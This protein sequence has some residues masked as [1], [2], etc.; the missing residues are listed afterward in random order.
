MLYKDINFSLLDEDFH[1]FDREELLQI[2]S[3]AERLSSS[4]I[5]YHKI[6]SEEDFIKKAHRHILQVTYALFKF[7]TKEQGTANIN[8]NYESTTSYCSLNTNHVQIGCKIL[9]NTDV[10]FQLRVDTIIALVFHELYHKRFTVKSISDIINIQKKKYYSDIHSELT[11]ELLEKELPTELHKHLFNI[12]EDKRIEFLGCRELPG[13]GFYFD[14]LRKFAYYLHFKNTLPG[15]TISTPLVSLNHVFYKVLIPEF[16]TPISKKLDIELP[17]LI[18]G[19]ELKETTETIE[20]IDKYFYDN[21]DKVYSTSLKTI[22]Q[23]VNDLEKL[24]PERLKNQINQ[25]L[26]KEGKGFM[27]LTYHPDAIPGKFQVL[28][29]QQQKQ[30]DS[31]S[32]EVIKNL[33]K[34]EMP[35]NAGDETNHMQQEK[36]NFGQEN[37]NEAYTKY[38]IHD[39]NHYVV[40][41]NLKREAEKLGAAIKRNLA[42]LDSRYSK[43]IL[44]HELNEGEIDD[45]E[46]FSINYNKSIFFTEED[47]ESYSLDFGLL[48]DESGS[49]RGLIEEAKKAILALLL[50]T[51]KAKHINLFVYGHTAN[52]NLSRTRDAVQL[53]RYYNS[54]EK[55]LNPDAIFA[56]KSRSNNADGYA[57]LKMGEIM[58]KSKSKN[59]IL[60]V[61]SDGLPHAS[62]YG[63]DEAIAH[64]RSA[65]LQLEK[66][67][68]TTIQVCMSY[69]EQSSKMFNHFVQY[70]DNINFSKNLNNILLKKL[71]EFSNYA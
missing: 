46:L 45:T 11:S 27:S 59:K 25:F 15:E 7:I 39:L 6:K 49:M 23:V 33:E 41:N 68:I 2:K 28:T 50:A 43:I 8:F 53:I 19:D 21:F 37:Q 54:L 48:L 36:L 66:A 26:D 22:F 52:S 56:A 69:I 57:L 13:Y 61:A 16:S 3:L 35:N 64:T 31:I 67:G 38:E 60:I 17:T 47:I 58:S 71:I 55:K 40:D 5:N 42:Y 12:L 1:K 18:S 34:S 44:E 30:L 65:V 14:E 70:E 29:K 63:G 20:K 32:K 9:L 62:D 51:Y 24:Y 4:K 10:P